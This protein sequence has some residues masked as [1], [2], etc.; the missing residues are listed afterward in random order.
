MVTLRT[1]HMSW[2]W[3]RTFGC[4]LEKQAA[5]L[6]NMCTGMPT[7]LLIFWPTSDRT[8][9]SKKFGLIGSLLVV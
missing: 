6:S 9:I 4:L 5:Q 3:L 7:R 8:M 2:A 1:N